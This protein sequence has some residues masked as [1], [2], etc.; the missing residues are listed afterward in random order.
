MPLAFQNEILPDSCRLIGYSWLLNHFHLNIPLRELCC[1]SEKRLASQKIQKNHWTIFDLQLSVEENP[2]GNLEFALK[3]E[4]IDLL[5]LKS[6][7]KV[8]SQESLIK[9]IQINPKRI[10]RKKIWFLYEFLLNQRLPIENLPV[11]KYDDLLDPKKYIIKNLPIKSQ[12]HKLNN[13]LLGTAKMC[14]I[15]TKTKKLQDYRERDLS[16]DISNV[17]GKVSQ[18]LVRRAASFLLLS[19]SKASFEI[20]GERPTKNRIENWGKII[21]EAGKA[22]LSIDEIERLHAILLEDTRFMKIGLRD[23]EVFLGER[24]RDNYPLPEFIGAKSEDL[25]NLLQDWIELDASLSSDEIDPI[26]H[27]VIIAFSFVYIHPL[28]DGNGRIHRYII[29]HVLAHRNFYPKGMIFPISS[30][31]LDEIE[32]YRD[33]LVSH[34]RPLMSLIDWEATPSGNVKVINDTQ[35]LYRYF[36]CTQSCEFIYESVERTIKETLP[37]ELSYLNS[38]DKAYEE[39]NDFIVMPDNKIKS[40]ITFILQNDG[41]LSKNKQEKYYEKLTRDEVEIIEKILDECFV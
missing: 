39:I 4:T 16:D 5:V 21:N 10:L 13:N 17:I 1:I 25:N 32:K 34:T 37:D 22:H 3:H 14:P 18:S 19:D 8:L 28:E 6:I 29:H 31:I 12:R 15:I 23:E 24:D 2:Y 36:N 9:Y 27:A 40:L 35:N 7:L 26:L 11:G 38:F 30:V 41:K 33:I 20:E